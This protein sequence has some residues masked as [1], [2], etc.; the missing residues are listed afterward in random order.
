MSAIPHQPLARKNRF[1]LT[2][3]DE[4]SDDEN[5]NNKNNEN[6]TASSQQPLE[7]DGTQ[8]PYKKFFLTNEG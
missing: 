6:K 5:N 4:D 3:I 8:K 7:T 1:K 2:P